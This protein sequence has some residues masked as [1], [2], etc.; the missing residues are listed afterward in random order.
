MFISC[1]CSRFCCIHCLSIDELASNPITDLIMSYQWWLTWF[2][3]FPIDF[4]FLVYVLYRFLWQPG[5]CWWWYQ[6]IQHVLSLSVSVWGACHVLSPN[7]ILSLSW[8][9]TSW[10][11][12]SRGEFFGMKHSNPCMTVLLL[13][14]VSH[15]F[16]ICLLPSSLHDSR[17][18][19][20]YL[21]VS[22]FLYVICHA[23]SLMR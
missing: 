19:F 5:H 21:F 14:R 8:S 11:S 18:E 23:W 12:S 9:C 4:L 22:C 2:R 7:N 17:L 6:S 13:E 1:F 20:W 10:S 15:L 16:L 3:R